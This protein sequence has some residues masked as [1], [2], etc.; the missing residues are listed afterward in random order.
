MGRRRAVGRMP[1]GKTLQV[2][3]TRV[4][5]NP[6]VPVLRRA[7]HVLEE[8]EHGVGAHPVGVLIIPGGEI[9]E[10]GAARTERAPRAGVHVEPGPR[11]G[12]LGA[13][14]RL[15]V[16]SLQA[17]QLGPGVVDGGRDVGGHGAWGQAHG[18]D[19]QVQRVQ[20]R[21][22]GAAVRVAVTPGAVA[23]GVVDGEDLDAAQAAGGSQADKLDQIFEV[24]APHRLAAP[25]AEH[26]HRDTGATPGA[27][28]VAHVAAVRQGGSH[29]A[30]GNHRFRACQHP[31]R[32][33]FTAHRAAV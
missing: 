15:I 18:L 14:G 31:W 7:E 8:A 30:G 2:S 1:R 20:G 24:A 33:G 13:Q 11:D 29:V 21:R 23:A 19:A 17:V 28:R 26:R 10:M 25:Q 4:G 6:P 32:A 16:H 5:Q 22:A 27:V 3:R 9:S 12:Q